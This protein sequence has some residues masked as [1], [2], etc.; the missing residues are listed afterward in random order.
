MES[1]IIVSNI[2][3]LSHYAALLIYIT[4][5]VKTESGHPGPAYRLLGSDPRC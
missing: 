4:N 2:A 1:F 5:N 3:Q